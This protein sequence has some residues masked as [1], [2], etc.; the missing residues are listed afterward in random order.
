MHTLFYVLLAFAACD[1]KDVTVSD[2]KTEDG[3]LVHEV[4][5]P[6]QAGT[7]RIRV[8]LPDAL[9]AAMKPGFAGDRPRSTGAGTWTSASRV[10]SP[11]FHSTF[12]SGGS[13]ATAVNAATQP[14]ASAIPKR[15]MRAS[16][17]VSCVA[18]TVFKPHAVREVTTQR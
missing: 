3:F 11:T 1:D 12:L 8:L 6:Y 4:K 10:A 17:D 14:T 15:F 7:T 9:G 16:P 13:A 2:A 5:S 18:P